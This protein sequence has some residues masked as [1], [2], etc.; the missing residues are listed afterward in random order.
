MGAEMCIRDSGKS[1]DELVARAGQEELDEPSKAR[2]AE[3]YRDRQL[4]REQREEL[5][6]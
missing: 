3:L 6:K 2:L 4:L 5:G 1:I